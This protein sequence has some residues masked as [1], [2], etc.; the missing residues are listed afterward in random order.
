V[1]E[2]GHTVGKGVLKT[3]T[4]GFSNVRQV[5]ARDIFELRRVYPNVPNSALEEL[6]QMNKMMYPGILLK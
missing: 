6:I 1:P 3:G 5:L 4:S 2:L